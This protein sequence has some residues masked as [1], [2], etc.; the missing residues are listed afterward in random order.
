MGSRV[1]APKARHGTTPMT[2]DIHH[3]SFVATAARVLDMH[4][5]RWA[6]R[7]G[8]KSLTVSS[9]PLTPHDTRCHPCAGRD[10][11]HRLHQLRVGSLLSQG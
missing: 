2:L 11:F 8:D 6:G 5:I 4:T 1:S 9:N 7:C 10:P 3:R